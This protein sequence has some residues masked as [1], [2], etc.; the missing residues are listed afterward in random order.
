[1]I[2]GKKPCAHKRNNPNPQLL[3]MRELD[4]QIVTQSPSQGVFTACI[5]STNIHAYVLSIP[6]PPLWKTKEAN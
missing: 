1:M 3:V 6:G 4:V 2:V 5:V